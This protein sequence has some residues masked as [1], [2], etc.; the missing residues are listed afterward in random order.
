MKNISDIV[1]EIESVE[2][3]E[4]VKS[5]AYIASREVDKAGFTRVLV[6]F[7]D[8]SNLPMKFT[9]KVPKDEEIIQQAL[10]FINSQNPTKEEIIEK[11]QETKRIIEEK[12]A[13]LKNEDS[14][15]KGIIEGKI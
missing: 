13:Q 6:V 1:K 11:L 3:K 14:K 5:S 12:L 8:G 9:E 2:Y 15:D 10:N 4:E 7:E